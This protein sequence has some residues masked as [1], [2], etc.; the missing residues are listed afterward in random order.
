MIALATLPILLLTLFPRDDPSIPLHSWGLCLACGDFGGVDFLLNIALFGPLGLALHHADLPLRRTAL[1]AFG[2]TLG[3]EAFQFLFLP[4]RF[5]ALG[6]LVANTSGG[7]LGWILGRTW[8]LIATP[9]PAMARR[10]AVLSLSGVA[11]IFGVTGWLLQPSLPLSTWFGQW[12]PEL[13]QFDQFAGTVD[14]ARLGPRPLPGHML[15]DT[16]E[17]R[18]E[19]RDGG[20][21]IAIRAHGTLGPPPRRTAP[22]VSVFDDRQRQ[23]ALLGQEREDLVVAIRLRSADARL[24]TPTLRVPDGLSAPA[25]TRY[26]AAGWWAEGTLTGTAVG[27]GSLPLTIGLGWSF[28]L[29]FGADLEPGV[30]VWSI[31]WLG[32]LG[33]LPG[34]FVWRGWRS[35][36][37]GVAGAGVLIGMALAASWGWALPFPSLVE[38][39][40]LAV[41]YLL[42]WAVGGGPWG[43]TMAGSVH[44][45][46]R[47]VTRTTMFGSVHP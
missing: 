13:G 41:G 29:P 35:P 30:P 21:P 4:G 18:L 25:G 2:L 40:A 46:G 24:R 39:G 26:D 45:S 31:L 7:V 28:V 14:S 23:V 11:G 34:R 5:A 17:R 9:A 8:P 37:S 16:W 3:I 6:D 44:P 36:L 10:I 15:V 19:L 33:L 43:P 32:L 1:V 20:G 27:T 38:V 22:I 42:G 47:N 12:R